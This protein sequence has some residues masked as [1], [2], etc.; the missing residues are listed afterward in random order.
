M[1]NTPT[2]STHFTNEGTPLHI[3]L[4]RTRHWNWNASV[5]LN[6]DRAMWSQS[7][8][9]QV[10]YV[11]AEEEVESTDADDA[12]AP[13]IFSLL[14]QDVP[15]EEMVVDDGH[16]SPP[17]V[18]DDTQFDERND[19]G[20]VVEIESENVNL[21]PAGI[22]MIRIIRTSFGSYPPVNDENHIRVDNTVEAASPQSAKKR[23]LYEMTAI[24]WCTCFY[25][26]IIFLLSNIADRF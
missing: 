18:E 15:A 25:F 17:I 11:A 3:I 2:I 9:Q 19:V 26:A 8:N 1:N 12:P 21:A 4:E 10:P 6:R 16:V 13:D 22:P 7:Y 23:K 14:T 20:A 24:I 5:A